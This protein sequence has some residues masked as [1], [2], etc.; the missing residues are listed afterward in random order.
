VD[1]NRAKRLL[2]ETFRIHQQELASP[3][4]IVLIARSSIVGRDRRSVERDFLRVMRASGLLK[5]S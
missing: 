5:V 3:V 1:R 4:E 2:R